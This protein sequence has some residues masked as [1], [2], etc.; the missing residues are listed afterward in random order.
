MRLHQIAILPAL[1]FLLSTVGVVIAAEK[2]TTS[3]L[4]E[5]TQF[6]PESGDC[7]QGKGVLKITGFEGNTYVVGTYTGE[8]K[9]NRPHGAGELVSMDPA[10]SGSWS[11]VV[12]GT[13]K[14]GGYDGVI[15]FSFP[16]AKEP[17]ISKEVYTY[18]DDKREGAALIYDGK[19][20]LV[21]I[22][23]YRENQLVSTIFVESDGKKIP[24]KY[25]VDYL[26]SIISNSLTILS[27]YHRALIFDEYYVKSLSDEQTVKELFQLQQ[28]IDESQERFILVKEKGIKV[29]EP[30]TTG[31]LNLFSIMHGAR[32][33]HLQLDLGRPMTRKYEFAYTTHFLGWPDSLFYTPPEKRSATSTVVE[34]IKKINVPSSLTEGLTVYLAPF[35]IGDTN[36]YYEGNFDIITLL[37]SGPFPSAAGPST[38]AHEMGHAVHYR[39]LDEKGWEEYWSLRNVPARKSEKYAWK[40]EVFAED[41]RVLYGNSERASV[42]RQGEWRGKYGDIREFPDQKEK[43]R[44]FIDQK[45]SEYTPYQSILDWGKITYN[46]LFTPAEEIRIRVKRGEPL[47][48]KIFR[49]QRVP[50]GATERYQ[51]KITRVQFNGFTKGEHNWT[52]PPRDDLPWECLEILENNKVVHTCRPNEIFKITI[53]ETKKYEGNYIKYMEPKIDGPI[54]YFAEKIEVSAKVLG[55]GE[56]VFSLKDLPSGFYQ[57]EISE[58]KDAEMDWKYFF[59]VYGE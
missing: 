9:D 4:M 2:Q 41:F 53:D 45:I 46:R 27:K 40:N 59:M 25:S 32:L 16:D 18:Q 55:T 54:E 23:E 51:K 15:T 48:T 44:E 28:A 33:N 43:V 36:G 57:L 7:M 52:F 50:M 58:E 39:L 3:F 21:L 12:K 34:A 1:I 49:F 56:A 42:M 30:E 47:Q 6:T 22:H 5:K 13:W 17:N 26:P 8:C 14:N 20:R 24:F 37:G 11:R 38:I 19:G 31:R 35:G 29:Y 10:S